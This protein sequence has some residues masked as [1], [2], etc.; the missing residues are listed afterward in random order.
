L[1]PDLL[2]REHAEARRIAAAAGA[3]LLALH[4][5]RPLG[6]ALGLE[7]DRLAHGEIVAA[8]RAAFPADPVLSEEGEAPARFGERLWVVDPLDGTRGYAEGRPDWAVHVA[9][10]VGVQP[11]VGTVAL[12]AEGLVFSTADPPPLPEARRDRL[13]IVV[14]RTR[15]PPLARR[16][17]EL[18]GAELVAQ[19][20]AG[21]KTMAVVRGEADVYLHAGGQHEWDSAAPVAVARAVGLHTSRVDGSPLRYAQPGH[22]LPDLLI[23]RPELAA[24]VLAA[25]R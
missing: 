11:L 3:G 14:S 2:A 9:L 17:A 12:P 15:P 19:G 23:C 21:A 16:V 18:L 24:M 22:W 20:S 7:G 13:R 4:A 1:P 10:V 25:V 6:P 8:L 5:T